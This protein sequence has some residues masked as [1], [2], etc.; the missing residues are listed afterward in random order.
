V[1]IRIEG[2]DGFLRADAQ[3]INAG[4]ESVN[5]TKSKVAAAIDRGVGKYLIGGID[6]NLIEVSIEVGRVGQNSTG[7][8]SVNSPVEFFLS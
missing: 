3:L 2:D 8:F 5:K 4:F 1:V 6:P 7:E